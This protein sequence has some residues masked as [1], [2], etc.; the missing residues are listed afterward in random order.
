MSL[1]NEHLKFTRAVLDPQ[2]VGNSVYGLQRLSSSMG[3]VRELVTSL[4]KNIAK[5]SGSLTTQQQSNCCYGLQ[6]MNSD[7][8]E[9][10]YLVKVLV[11]RISQSHTKKGDAFSAQAFGTI[12][13]LI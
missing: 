2:G 9:V 13:A 1:I 6:R 12:N 8:P 10:R 11:H 3:E 5:G 7:E 4:S